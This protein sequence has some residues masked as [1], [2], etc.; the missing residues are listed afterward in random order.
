MGVARA[1]SSYFPSPTK[2]SSS[3]RPPSDHHKSL[4]RPVALSA[5]V[6]VSRSPSACPPLV[7]IP[8]ARRPK[9]TNETARASGECV[10]RRHAKSS[11][12]E[13]RGESGAYRCAIYRLRIVSPAESPL[14]EIRRNE[15][16]ARKDL[17]SA[18]SRRVFLACVLSARSSVSRSPESI[19]LRPSLWLLESTVGSDA[20][21]R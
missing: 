10:S 9:Q 15:D 13:G 6:R 11:R 14:S 5:R 8:G 2:A 18:S 17:G 1:R 16:V 19:S 12:N 4:L 7:S 21:A 3:V 20:G